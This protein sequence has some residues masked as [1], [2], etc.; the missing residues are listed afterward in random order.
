MTSRGSLVIET[1]YYHLRNIRFDVFRLRWRDLNTLAPADW[2]AGDKIESDER[3]YVCRWYSSRFVC[4]SMLEGSTPQTGYR[5]L[6]S[7]IRSSASHFA[8]DLAP[9]L[10]I[11]QMLRLS[12]SLSLFLSTTRA[13]FSK[14]HHLYFHS[15]EF[16]SQRD[17]FS[18]NTERQK[19][20]VLQGFLFI[21]MLTFSNSFL[22]RLF[23][24]AMFDRYRH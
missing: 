7:T 6:S 13:I 5:D 24:I 18:Y 21:S 2:L 1:S 16:T 8:N 15:D 4:A 17:I 10:L 22:A 20:F 23:V 19:E 11:C 9:I 14:F 12:L 3:G